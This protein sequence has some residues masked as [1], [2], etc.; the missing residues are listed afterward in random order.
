MVI[1]TPNLEPIQSPKLPKSC[2]SCQYRKSPPIT[3]VAPRAISRSTSLR[4]PSSSPMNGA[5]AG[6]IA[7]TLGCTNTTNRNTDPAHAIPAMTWT[8]RNTIR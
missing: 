8:I 7:A 4:L 1:A 2:Q 5:P 3:V 6:A